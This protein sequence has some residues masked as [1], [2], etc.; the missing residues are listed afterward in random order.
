MLEFEDRE[1]QLYGRFRSAR[2]QI[3]VKESWNQFPAFLHERFLR[4][5]V[6]HGWQRLNTSGQFPYFG[7]CLDDWKGSSRFVEKFTG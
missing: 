1:I 5:F 6:L 7:E 2:L 4:G 3:I